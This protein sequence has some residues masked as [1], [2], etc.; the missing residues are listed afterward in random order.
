MLSF[1]SYVYTEIELGRL[2]GKG[3]FFAVSEVK[4]ITLKRPDGEEEGEEEG[5][6]STEEMEIKRN[7][8]DAIQRVVQDRKFMQK[9]CIR[10]GSDYRYAFKTM[11]KSGRDDPRKFVDT[12]V[13]L[14]I[15]FKFLASVR[16]P[17]ILKMRAVS[18]D[19][20][21]SDSFLVLDKIYDT[22]TTRMEKWKKYDANAFNK[23]FDFHK[24]REKEFL[25]KR[26]LVAYDIA[27]ALAYLHDMK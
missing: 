3:G 24:K 2:L 19:I 6:P 22:L 20:F 17:N 1:F 26:L 15:E 12:V 27:S 5:N 9:Y 13:D 18:E 4:K 23:L 10:H 14:A 21:S 8:E 16:H 11:K 25:A 7:D